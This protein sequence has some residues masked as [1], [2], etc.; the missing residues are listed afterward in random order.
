M[1]IATKGQLGR[2]AGAAS[3]LQDG[4]TAGERMPDPPEVARIYDDQIPAER[5]TSAVRRN[6]SGAGQRLRHVFVGRKALLGWFG[7]AVAQP[8]EDIGDHS[9]AQYESSAELIDDYSVIPVSRVSG[10]KPL[11]T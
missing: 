1:I 8:P 7:E 3:R 6:R 5:L 2:R 4:D 11:W 9:S 10:L